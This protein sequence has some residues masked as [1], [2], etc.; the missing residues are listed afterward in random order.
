MMRTSAL[1]LTTLSLVACGSFVVRTISIQGDVTV[2]MP[3]SVTANPTRVIYS[4]RNYSSTIQGQLP[5]Y[6]SL[7]LLGKATYVGSGTVTKL[8][9][10]VR[11]NLTNCQNAGSYAICESEDQSGFAIGSI[12]LPSGG[13]ERSGSFALSGNALNTYARNGSPMYFGVAVAEGSTALAGDLLTL[14]NLVA[15]VRL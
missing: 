2:P 10:Y 5:G 1:V 7:R 13:T 12:T 4:T 9:V 14:S 3:P 8:N 11:P 15:E 6:L